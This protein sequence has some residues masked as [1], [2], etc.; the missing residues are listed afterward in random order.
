MK[1]SVNNLKCTPF[2]S[3]EYNKVL[4]TNKKSYAKFSKQAYNKIWK[5]HKQV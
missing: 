1:V 4:Y 3:E 5:F 2:T